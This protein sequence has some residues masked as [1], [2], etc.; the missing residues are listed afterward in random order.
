MAV[1]ARPEQQA[2]SQSPV[3]EPT[4]LQLLQRFE[5]R[6]GGAAAVV[7]ESVQRLLAFLALRSR[8]Q[9]RATVAGVLWMDAPERRADGNLRTTVWRARKIE[10][11]LI[12]SE[13]AYLCIGAHVMVDLTDNLVVTRQLVDNPTAPEDPGM[14]VDALCDDLLPAWYDDW[15]LLERERLRQIRLHGLEALCVRLTHLRRYSHAIE[16]GVLAAAEEPLRESTQYAL[17]SAHVAEGNLAEA[18]RQYDRYAL[19]LDEQLGI[20][21]SDRLRSLVTPCR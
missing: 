5:L 15:V 17:I 10:R 13:G 4:R 16:A 3:S 8:P 9:H 6:C 19:V 12:R 1:S 18:V 14:T 20:A 11:D 7:P 21:P 2:A